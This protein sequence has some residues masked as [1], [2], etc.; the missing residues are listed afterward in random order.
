MYRKRFDASNIFASQLCEMKYLQTILL[1]IIFQIDANAQF[2]VRV[3]DGDTYK[4]LL[5]GKLKNVRLKNVDAPEL[6]QFFGVTSKNAVKALIEGR[7]V[8]IQIKATDL[9]GRL[10]VAIQ[11]DGMS[12]D[13]LLIRKGLAW[14]YKAYC[15]DK[16]LL[17]C[18]ALAKSKAIGLWKCER[19][20]PP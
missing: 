17:L 9:Y 1:F 13:K 5:D 19:N 7:R 8:A 15:K 3:I 2:V 4:I 11:V 16:K 12:L 20:I 14:V 18:E 10:I 6:K